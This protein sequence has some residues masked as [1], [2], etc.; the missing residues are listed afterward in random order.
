MNDSIIVAP[1]RAILLDKSRIATHEQ[2]MSGYSA[3]A[4]ACTAGRP[5]AVYNCLRREICA[6]A[7]EVMRR[8]AGLT[9]IDLLTQYT[10][11]YLRFVAALE[12]LHE[13]FGYL[14]RTWAGT[15]GQRGVAPRPGVHDTTALGLLT[16]RDQ[17][18][19]PLTDALHGAMLD[20]IDAERDARDGGVE[21]GGVADAAGTSGQ[22]L[23]PLAAVLSGL[24][25][26][27][28]ACDRATALPPIRQ[29]Q[30]RAAVALGALGSIGRGFGADGGDGYAEES[31]AEEEDDGLGDDGDEDDGCDEEAAW[32]AAS[33][34]ADDDPGTSSH[35]RT[36]GASSSLAEHGPSHWLTSQHAHAQEFLQEFSDDD[37]DDDS[38]DDSVVSFDAAPAFTPVPHTGMLQGGG[39]AGSSAS[40]AA[41]SMAEQL[42]HHHHYHTHHHHHPTSTTVYGG[43]SNYPPA[44]AA[45]RGRAQNP[46]LA[47]SPP[48]ASGAVGSLYLTF[49]AVLLARTSSYF[50]ARSE[51]FL[52]GAGAIAYLEWVLEVFRHE[53]ALALILP[54]R[55]SRK[56]LFHA[57]KRTLLQD[58]SSA[59]D[60][61]I[62]PLL[63]AEDM[64]GLR[65]MYALLRRLPHG[66]HHMAAVLQAHILSIA[67]A[68][69]DAVKNSRA[70]AGPSSITAA[71]SSPASSSTTA[72]SSP[73]SSRTD[74]AE[75]VV[76]T[77]G[78]VPSYGGELDIDA[79]GNTPTT[80]HS[81][82][83]V[84]ALIDAALAVHTK[85]ARTH[86]HTS[87]RP[88]LDASRARSRLPSAHAPCD[89]YTRLPIPCALPLA[90]RHCAPGLIKWCA[91]YSAPTPPLSRSSRAAAASTSTPRPM[92]ASSSQA[93][94]RCSSP[95]PRRTSSRRRPP[96]R[97]Y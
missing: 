75:L 91:T 9:G 81:V 11:E 59:I 71:S 49:E 84:E 79:L 57:L 8:L 83:Y 88:S 30:P 77:S 22:R 10:T 27:G 66:L 42:Q 25:E 54:A 1:T 39:A 28:L 24:N 76:T 14:N 40:H 5:N 67:N 13:L 78:P 64:R 82:A 93:I 87:A 20:A 97:R 70:A 51:P 95:P 2:W 21:N 4:A 33:G 74:D 3:V 47:A 7:E 38:E 19:A 26:L 12:K 73:S 41:A 94:A 18:V 32:V 96:P 62:V 29:F 69:L 56:H 55:R 60:D 72:A 92:S 86:T 31:G 36:I 63:H 61:A 89:R 48:H 37:D 46:N 68:A 15:H 53:R 80:V 23:A 17:L 85:Y 16:W 58:R 43:P 50:E 44:S 34:V 90:S 6:A 52:H 45:P 65:A 35:H